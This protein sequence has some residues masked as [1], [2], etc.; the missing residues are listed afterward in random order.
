MAS[1]PNAAAGVD[2]SWRKKG[3]RPGP[4]FAS[5]VLDLSPAWFQAAHEVS[6]IYC[7]FLINSITVCRDSKIS[8]TYQ[9]T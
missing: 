4:L 8:S 7:V 6:P 1:L 5:G 2:P 9:A 3:F